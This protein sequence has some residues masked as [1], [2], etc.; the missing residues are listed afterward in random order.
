MSKGKY[1]PSLTRGMISS[2][3]ANTFIYN[4]DRQLP[5]ETWEEGGYNSRLHLAHYDKEGYDSYGYSAFDDDGN[6]I[7]IGE[8]IDR[9]GYTEW[10]YLAMTDSE[11]EYISM[12]GV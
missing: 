3:D 10:D 2:W 5:P 12:Y 1:S 9:W 4:A 11:F 7:G 8:G 6:Y